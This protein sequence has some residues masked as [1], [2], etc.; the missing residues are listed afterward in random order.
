MVIHCNKEHFA[1]M[2]DWCTKTHNQS[3]LVERCLNSKITI[4]EA[5]NSILNWLH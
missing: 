2:D 4:E 3:G 5:E 1:T